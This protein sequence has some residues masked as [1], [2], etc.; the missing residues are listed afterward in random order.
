[1]YP[2]SKQRDIRAIL[3]GCVRAPNQ[4]FMQITKTLGHFCKKIFGL[5]KHLVDIYGR[6]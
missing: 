6:N 5:G 3:L 1:M 2:I 4:T